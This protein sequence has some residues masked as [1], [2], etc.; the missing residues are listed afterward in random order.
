LYVLYFNW[1][2]EFTVS[3]V[4]RRFREG[5]DVWVGKR[6]VGFGVGGSVMWGML[7]RMNLEALEGFAQKFG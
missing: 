2:S 4:V 3:G 7:R 1:F 5:V 6:V